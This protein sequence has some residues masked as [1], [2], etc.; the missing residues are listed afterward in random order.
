MSE[1]ATQDHTGLLNVETGELL[2]ATIDNAVAALI[3]ARNMKERV[4]EI[5]SETTAFLVSESTRLGTKTLP[6]GSTTVSLSGG[7]SDEYD[8]HDLMQLLRESGC[9]EDRIEQAVTTEISY[10]V[11]RAVLRQLAAAN[12]DYKAAIELARR[13]VERPYR[14]SVRVS[15]RKRT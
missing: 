15:E 4:N 9:P 13:E 8:A 12:P 3:A 1:L 2:P 7:V 10:K 6:A 14:A 5:V 11:N